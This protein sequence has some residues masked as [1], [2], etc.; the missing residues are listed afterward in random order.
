MSHRTLVYILGFIMLAYLAKAFSKGDSDA[1]ELGFQRSADLSGNTFHFRMPENF[2]KDMPAPPLNTHVDLDNLA[3]A[4]NEEAGRLLQRWWDV[5]EPGWFGKELGTVMMDISVREVAEN[6]SK[7]FWKEPFEIRDRFEYLLMID[8]F[9][10][11][12]VQ[13][14]NQSAGAEGNEET[15]YHNSSFSMLGDKVVPFFWDIDSNG[16]RW[17]QSG[18]TGPN[19]VIYSS[20]SIPLTDKHF[21]EVM[22]IYAVAQGTPGPHYLEHAKKI[23]APILDS[24][25]VQYIRDNPYG[26][27]VESDWQQVGVE[28]LVAKRQELLVKQFTPQQT[29][30]AL[31][32]APE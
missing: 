25:Q 28:Q 4:E 16:Q 27:L 6:R 29:P 2:S 11:Q 26:R 30:E 17:L 24:L 8:E 9:M 12:R 15:P 10:H 7:R 19:S 32:Q 31:N 13:H 22:F 20:Y 3:G 23:T 14:L 18:F 5:E 1:L 21:L